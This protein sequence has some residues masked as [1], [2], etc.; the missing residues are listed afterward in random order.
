MTAAPRHWGPLLG[1]LIGHTVS[2]TGN[3]LTYIAL[4][5][6]VLAETGSPAATGLTGACAAEHHGR[7][8][9]RP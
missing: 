4:P 6:Y 7:G 9:E 8:G 1:L 3:M 2:L 5:L